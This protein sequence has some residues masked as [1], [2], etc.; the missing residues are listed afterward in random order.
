[1]PLDAGF[2]THQEL[3]SFLKRG[4]GF[5]KRVDAVLKL[6]QGGLRVLQLSCDLCRHRQC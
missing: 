6:R 2:C 1:M 4:V 3:V 5:S